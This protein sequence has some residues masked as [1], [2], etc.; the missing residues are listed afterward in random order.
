MQIICPLISNPLMQTS[1]LPVGFSLSIAALDL[2]GSVTGEA[3]QFGQVFPQPAGIIDQLSSG[4]SGKAFQ[5][6]VNANLSSSRCAL[7]CRIRQF[8]H[9]VNVP[10]FVNLLDDDV[11]DFRIGQ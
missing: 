2:S 5:A 7:R 1:N 6:K 10:P 9:Q 4:E 3:A 11:F 8:E